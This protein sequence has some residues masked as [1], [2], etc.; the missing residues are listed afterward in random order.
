[1]RYLPRPCAEFPNDNP[2]LQGLTPVTA[3]AS[4]PQAAAI[5][6]QPAWAGVEPVRR[7]WAMLRPWCVEGD[8]FDFADSLPSPLPAPVVG[9]D[10]FVDALMQE[11]LQ[12]VAEEVARGEELSYSER[13]Y[14]LTPT[15]G[16]GWLGVSA[17]EQSPAPVSALRAIAPSEP[18]TFERLPVEALNPLAPLELDL[19][20]FPPE[21][22]PWGMVVTELSR[23]LLD[24]G[25]IRSAT[26]VAPLVESER[27]N[28]RGLNAAARAAVLAHGIA[29]PNAEDLWPAQSFRKEA[30][31]FR[32]R[33]EAGDVGPGGR[34]WLVRLLSALLGHRDV[35]H[36]VRRD[37]EES[38]LHELTERLRAA[39]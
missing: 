29:E 5:V 30:T 10:P 18:P 35:S 21:T 37:F 20:P 2:D 33:F 34:E 15:S 36:E 13:P 38:P 17:R 14:E 3:V 39:G 11:V 22:S 16:T 24:Q 1:M 12:D 19:S 8:A 6:V 32:A 25:A 28:L 27:V 9:V 7:A 4:E 31:A 23:F 26:L